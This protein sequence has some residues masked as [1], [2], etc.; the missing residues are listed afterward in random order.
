MKNKSGTIAFIGVCTTLAL[1]LAYLEIII[2][3]LFPSVPGI[4]MGLANIIIIF[5]LY[6][7]GTGYAVT[8]SLLRLILVGLLFG[9][10]MTFIYSLVGAT[11]SLAVMVLL[12]RFNFLST[13]GVSVAGAVLHNAGQ[14]LTAMVLLETAQLG[15]YMAVLALTGT[16]SGILIG[17]CGAYLIKRIPEKF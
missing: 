10:A 2:P 12:R 11:L 5:I 15:Y 6:R 13:V 8:V 3:P 4:K 14:V 16:I 9:N 7:K 1:A 17:L